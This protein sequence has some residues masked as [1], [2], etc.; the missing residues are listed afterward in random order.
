MHKA[1]SPV[2]SPSGLDVNFTITALVGLKCDRHMLDCPIATL[3]VV[4]VL[5][6]SI[7]AHDVLTPYYRPLCTADV[8]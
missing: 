1:A 2:L 4:G 5:S 7:I 3:S 8:G 6:L